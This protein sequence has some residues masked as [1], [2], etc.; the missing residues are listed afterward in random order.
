MQKSSNLFSKAL[1]SPVEIKIKMKFS[2]FF[3]KA[4]LNERERESLENSRE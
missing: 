2:S 3:Q 4:F 1:I